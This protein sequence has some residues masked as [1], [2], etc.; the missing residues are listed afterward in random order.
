[1][2][3]MI[4]TNI[5]RKLMTHELLVWPS[6]YLCNL[7]G[8]ICPIRTATEVRKHPGMLQLV[9]DLKSGMPFWCTQNY[10]SALFSSK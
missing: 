8:Y 10:S 4:D 7:G 5:Y 6:F 3:V 1:M 9:L 2:K